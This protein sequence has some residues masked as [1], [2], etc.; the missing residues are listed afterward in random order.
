MKRTSR[1]LT[2]LVGLVMTLT[3]SSSVSFG[4][5]MFK[6]NFEKDTIGKPPANWEDIGFPKGYTG[7][8]KS[9]VDKDPEN[10]NNKVFH[11]GQVAMTSGLFM[12]SM[13]HGPITSFNGIGSFPKIP[14]AR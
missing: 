2:L 3:L 4:K 9:V 10:P 11:L 12:L 8:G 7:G 1:I 6:D 14:T 5:V 13:N